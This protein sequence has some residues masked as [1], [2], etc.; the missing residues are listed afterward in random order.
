MSL[1]SVTISPFLFLVLITC[2]CVFYDQYYSW[3]YQLPAFYVIVRH[4][5]FTD[6]L[7]PT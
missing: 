5:N 1:G 4:F 3:L 2:V 7:S 6:I